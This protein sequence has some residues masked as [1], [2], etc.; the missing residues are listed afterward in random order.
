MANAELEEK[1]RWHYPKTKV[2]TDLLSKNIFGVAAT[3]SEKQNV[4]KR[5]YTDKILWC[6][7]LIS[8]EEKQRDTLGYFWNH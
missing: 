5:Q 4:N 3:H 1:S 6:D 8:T 7:N 2:L